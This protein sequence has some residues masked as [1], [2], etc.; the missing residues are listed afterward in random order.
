LAGK[1]IDIDLVE[2]QGFELG[3]MF[4]NALDQMAP[5]IAPQLALTSNA[6]ECQNILIAEKNKILESLSKTTKYLDE[7]SQEEANG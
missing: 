5:R 7:D 1:T 3:K 6:L 2:K 4:K